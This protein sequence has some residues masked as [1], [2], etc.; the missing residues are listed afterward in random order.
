[1]STTQRWLVLAGAVLVAIALVYWFG[2][3][4]HDAHSLLRAL[5]R[6]L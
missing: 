2:A 5:R 4:G 1:M 6:A 3:S